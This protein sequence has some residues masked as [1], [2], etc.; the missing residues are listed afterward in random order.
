MLAI[1]GNDY[2]PSGMCSGLP[3]HLV[4]K[5]RDNASLCAFYNAIDVM[6]VPSRQEN[7]A[8]SATEAQSCGCPVVGFNCGGMPDVVDHL[9]TGFLA[10]PFD[11]NDLAEGITWTLRKNELTGR[12][13][14]N[15]RIRALK[16]WSFTEVL[17][18]YLKAYRETVVDYKAENKP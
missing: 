16:E 3:V 4:G 5:L 17:P 12:L 11:C 1:I 14:E 15:A 18:K 13:S 6:I 7:L 2:L 9:N 10:Q 8:Q